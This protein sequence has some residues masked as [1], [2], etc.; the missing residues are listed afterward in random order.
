MKKVLFSLI[1]III[2][3]QSFA[4]WSIIIVD[5]KTGTIGIAGASCTR[6]VYGIGTIVPGKGA[7]IVQAYSNSD[8]R[9]EGVDMIMADASP[10]EI[11]EAI[12]NSRFDPEHQQYAILTLKDVDHPVTYTGNLTTE[13]RGALGA[14]GIS[15]QG[16]T[17]VSEDVL[18]KAMEAVVVAQG[19][20]LSI[21][22]TLMLALEAGA[23]AGGDKRCGEFKASSAFITVMKPGD[24][25]KKPYFELIV[26]KINDRTNAVQ[27]LR[28]RFHR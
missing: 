17:L 18:K 15:I 22:E 28:E 14:K 21:E 7:I 3:T 20:G 5:E 24:S 6:S 19:K 9:E 25:N 27:V 13:V 26:N 2:A 1:L 11:M 12:R 4:T 8:A 16:N 10:D 23:E